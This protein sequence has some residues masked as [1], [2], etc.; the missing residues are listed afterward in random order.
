MRS[1]PSQQILGDPHLESEERARKTTNTKSE[2]REIKQNQMKKHLGRANDSWSFQRNVLRMGKW[3][4]FEKILT[5]SIAT[6]LGMPGSK[7][8][9]F[10][11]S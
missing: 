7:K 11:K 10:N 1:L 6:V 4:V 9:T 2:V 8:I 3:K 5:S